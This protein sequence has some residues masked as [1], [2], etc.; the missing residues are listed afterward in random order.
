LTGIG[1]VGAV[2]AA[3]SAAGDRPDLLNSGNR[4]DT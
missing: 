4:F 2:A 1:A 3:H